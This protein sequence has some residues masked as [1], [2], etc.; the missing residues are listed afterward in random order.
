[1]MLLDA[2]FAG[3][4]LQVDVADFGGVGGVSLAMPGNEAGMFPDEARALAAAL[5]AAAT[6][7]ERRSTRLK[8]RRDV[9]DGLAALDG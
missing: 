6:E 4:R 1:M 9:N 2:R 5:S 7:A 3:G 8:R